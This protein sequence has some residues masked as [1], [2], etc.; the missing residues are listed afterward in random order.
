MEHEIIRAKDAKDV[1]AQDCLVN[2]ELITATT[3]TTTTVHPASIR[4]V[5]TL[6]THNSKCLMFSVC[7]ER[8]VAATSSSPVVPPHRVRHY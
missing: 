1:Y 7:A 2:D 6:T 3:T 4:T 5:H 8:S